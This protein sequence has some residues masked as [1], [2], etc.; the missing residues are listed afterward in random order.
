M[1]R[2]RRQH[3]NVVVVS[4]VRDFGSTLTHRSHTRFQ[5]HT[6]WEG[7]MGFKPKGQKKKK[8]VKYT[9]YV[10]EYFYFYSYQLF[11]VVSTLNC[12]VD[13]FK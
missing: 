2:R 12:H 4:L 1:R 3:C 7:A 6:Q 9:K 10:L 13:K 8:K 11:Y 5:K